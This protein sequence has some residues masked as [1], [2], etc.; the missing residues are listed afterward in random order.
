MEKFDALV[1]NYEEYTDEQFVHKA[2]WIA[3]GGI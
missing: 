3:K 1:N 2:K